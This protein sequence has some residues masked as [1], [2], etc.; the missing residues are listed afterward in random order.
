LKYFFHKRRLLENWNSEAGKVAQIKLRRLCAA[1]ELHKK[2]KAT[3]AAFNDSTFAFHYSTA[4][5]IKLPKVQVSDTTMSN[6]GT[7][8]GSIK[9]KSYR[10]SFHSFN[11]CFHYSKAS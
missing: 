6:Q 3:E 1:R 2:T 10:S 5:S 7:I 9:N 11:L 8:A 4:G